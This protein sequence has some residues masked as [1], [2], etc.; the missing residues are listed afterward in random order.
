MCGCGRLDHVITFY[1]LVETECKGLN[2]IS[3]Y[4]EVYFPFFPSTLS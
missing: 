2:L 3:N 4:F 1:V